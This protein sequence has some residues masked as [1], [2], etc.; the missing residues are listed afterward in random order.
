MASV[1][2]SM[3]TDAD[4][5]SLNLDEIR[6][7]WAR[8][9]GYS[10][11]H[12]LGRRMLEDSIAFKIREQNGQGLTPVQQRQLKDLVTL[13][14]RDPDSF[15]TY[16]DNLKPGTRLVRTYKGKRHTVEITSS[17]YLYNDLI[18]NSLSKVAQEITGTSWNG[19]V[20]FGLKKA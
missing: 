4:I 18:Y 19:W 13:Y 11:P 6:T 10:P 15:E 1:T 9:W 7:L 3:N 20:F 8:Y 17:G 12:Y 14:K 16:H 2:V 5:T